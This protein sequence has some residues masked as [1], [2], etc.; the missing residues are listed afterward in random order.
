M[1][2][3]FTR[4]RSSSESGA[5]SACWA[6]TRSSAALLVF[7]FA[8]SAGNAS[9]AELV[10]IS[11][12]SAG[13]EQA[14]GDRD[15]VFYAI[16]LESDNHFAFQPRRAD[17]RHRPYSTFKIPNLLIALELGV[18]SSLHHERQWDESLRP[19]SSFWPA[20]W[21]QDQTLQTA[22]KRSVVWYFRDIAQEVGGENYRRTLDDFRYGNG[23]APDDNDLFWLNGPLKISPREQA[24]FLEQLVTGKLDISERTLDALREASFL[25]AEPDASLHG[26][27]GA[28]PVDPADF[29][30][31]FE[32]WLVGWVSR[33]AAAPVVYALYVRGPD[34]G[35]IRDFRREMSISFLREIGA[36]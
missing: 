31:E 14:I 24:M 28:G 11:D 12:T 30:G 8:L 34:F 3:S 22:F 1:I 26:K 33:P 10:D 29:D 35:S 9:L 2:E 23:Q 21:R 16:D 27:T 7:M 19:A 20:D 5:M 36:L 25:A 18:E 15:V 13:L 17:E 32:G 4:A 6:G